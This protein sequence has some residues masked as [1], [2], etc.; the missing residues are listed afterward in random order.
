MKK[1][2]GII[3][4]GLLIGVLSVLLVKLG[5]PANMGFCIAC[6]IR[7]TA[8]ALGLHSAGVVQYIRPEIIGLVFGSFVAA[9]AAKEFK[10]KAGSAPFTRFIL[11]VG[12]MIGALMFLGCPFRMVLRIAGGDLNAVIG[13]IGFVC[14]IFGGIFFLNKGFN[15]KR[16]YSI[17]SF[18]GYIFPVVLVGLLVLAIVAPPFIKISTEGPGSMSAPIFISLAAGFLVGFLGQKTRLCMVG[19]LRDAVLFKSGYLLWGFL[20]I[21]V[22][23][24]IMN[25]VFGYFHVGFEGQPVA[26]SDGLWNFLG[27]LVVGWG[28]V[29]L[30]GC[31]L[32]QLV[33]SG[34]GNSDSIITILG[35][36]VG[37]AI[38]HN[39]ALASAPSGP[40]FNGKIAV[41]LVIA[42]LA[43]ISVVNSGI[44]KKERV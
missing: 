34:E 1:N 2:L 32:R 15:L 44:L 27:M 9:L 41:I 3:T 16:N 39:F 30:G 20:A 5:N 19:G 43:I 21:I 17:S 18:E 8:G 38:C 26:H 22:S 28:S 6:F 37:A 13:L 35:L 25:F 36:L 42:V 14:G 11:G 29:L 23:A 12:V 24:A 4:A 31:P 10:A 7:D 40:S 33:L